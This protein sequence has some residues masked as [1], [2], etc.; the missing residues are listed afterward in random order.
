MVEARDVEGH[1]VDLARAID[2][3]LLGM[4]QGQSATYELAHAIRDSLVRSWGVDQQIA[5]GAS[6]SG[7]KPVQELHRLIP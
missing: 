2:P 1:M 4:T 7:L 6:A 5:V 3:E